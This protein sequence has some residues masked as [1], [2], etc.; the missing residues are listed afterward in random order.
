MLRTKSDEGLPGIVQGCR[1]PPEAKVSVDVSHPHVVSG[2]KYAVCCHSA[3]KGEQLPRPGLVHPMEGPQLGRHLLSTGA[4]P[5]TAE[6]L[7]RT[8]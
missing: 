6:K 5:S 3:Q 1:V 4:A 7:G 2:F 8:A